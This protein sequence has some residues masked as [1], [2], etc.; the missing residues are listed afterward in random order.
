MLNKLP[1][2]K[3]KKDLKLFSAI[4]RWLPNYHFY[5]KKIG[6]CPRQVNLSKKPPSRSND[7]C[8]YDQTGLCTHQALRNFWQAL[9]H[10]DL[11]TWNYAWTRWHHKDF[12]KSKSHVVHSP[13]KKKCV[14]K[15]NHVWSEHIPV[16]CRSTYCLDVMLVS[17][18]SLLYYCCSIF[19]RSDFSPKTWNNWSNHCNYIKYIQQIKVKKCSMWVEFVSP[20]DFCMHLSE[21]A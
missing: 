9:C 15:I 11:R 10:D 5:V 8:S 6:L 19:P 1:W 12:S 18:V 16:F 21:Y 20:V 7:W 4:V 14:V 3:N 13:A 17:I 2:K